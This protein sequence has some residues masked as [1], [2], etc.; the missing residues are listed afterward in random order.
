MHIALKNFTKDTSQPREASRVFNR[1]RF[2][3]ESYCD[4][5][6]DFKSKYS[7]QL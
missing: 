6:Y 1:N 4:I 3:V 2:V 5:Y 7:V